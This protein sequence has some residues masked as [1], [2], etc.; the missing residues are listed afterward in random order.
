MPPKAKFTRDEIIDEALNIVRAEGLGALTA[1]SLGAKLGSSA[2]PI[3]TLFQNMDEVQQEVV[4]AVK[5]LYAE[6]VNNGL[7][8][9]EMPAFKGVGMQYIRFAL[10]EPK[11]FQILFMSEHQ[12]KP[13]VTNV[14]PVIDDNYHQIL[15]SVQNSYS[16]N[17]ADSQWLYRHLW[18]YTHGIAVLCATN[19]CSFTPEEI[20]KM[21]T[22]VCTAM[23]K[24]MKGGREN[25]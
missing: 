24:E 22:E 19:M 3:F 18:I 8:Q 6:Y 10:A 11:L 15:S 23:L 5:R 7:C 21:L 4:A 9:T 2:R 20:G 12:Q 16:L 13:D 1:R 17:Q 14:L 25:D